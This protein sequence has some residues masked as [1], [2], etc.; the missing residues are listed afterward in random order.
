MIFKK[1]LPRRTF[2]QG[3]GTTLALPFLDSMAPAFASTMD[4]A[5]KT[6]TRLAFVYFPNGAIM[7]Q[8][9]PKAEGA[10]FEIPRTLQPLAPFRENT[11]VLS[12]LC[13][14]SVTRQP[15]DAGGDHPRAGAAWL[16]GV[17]PKKR[18]GTKGI[19]VDQIAAKELGKHTQLASLELTL[20][21]PDLVA[22][23]ED[24]YTTACTNTVS[25]SGATTPM[26]MEN[27]PRAIFERLFG[28]SDTTGAAGRMAR[29]KQNR[30]ILDFVSQATNRLMTGLGP[31]DRTR[32]SEYLESVRDVE[33]RIQVAEEQGDRELPAMDRPAGIPGSFDDYSKLMFDLQALAFQSDMTRVISFMMSREKSMRAYP[34][35]GIPDAHHALTHHAGDAQKIEKVTQI[36]TYHAKLFSYF[37]E[38]LKATPDGDGTLLDHSMMVYGSGLSDGNLHTYN[39]LPTLLVGGGAKVKMGRHIQYPKD[40]PMTNLYLTLLDKLGIAVE[41]FGDSTGRLELLTVA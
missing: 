18:T 41:N 24:G 23:T 25:W 30:S 12:G 11:L 21:S 33:R 22:V 10:A 15:G 1:S 13:H 27:Q 6:P 32:L 8:W 17:H 28:E 4:T 34:Q 3:L 36:D 38:K 29:L 26:P 9:T 19:S 20:D 31:G 37:L 35:I 39:P 14:N 16:T 5:A 40:T 2:L 7:N